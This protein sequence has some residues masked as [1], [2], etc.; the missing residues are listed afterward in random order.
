MRTVR[1]CDP[2][3]SVSALMHVDLGGKSSPYHPITVRGI[4]DVATWYPEYGCRGSGVR[5]VYATCRSFRGV[6]DRDDVSGYETVKG[7]GEEYAK[8]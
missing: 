8:C 5:K 1:S 4:R 6:K 7:L 2:F 3:S